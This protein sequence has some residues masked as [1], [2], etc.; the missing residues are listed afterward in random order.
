MPLLSR[1]ALEEIR[2][3]NVTSVDDYSRTAAHNPPPSSC[4]CRPEPLINVILI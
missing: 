2:I 4:T 1:D 3:N